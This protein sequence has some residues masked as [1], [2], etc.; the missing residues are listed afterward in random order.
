[1]RHQL[2]VC[3]QFVG[4]RREP[5]PLHG[6]RVLGAR[7]VSDAISGRHGEQPHDVILTKLARREARL[8]EPALH[9]DVVGRT[10][11]VDV[12]AAEHVFSVD[13]AMLPG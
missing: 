8:L 3:Q 9:V 2:L 11:A 1:M 4:V 6:H 10:E 5:L 12:A 7:E 13:V